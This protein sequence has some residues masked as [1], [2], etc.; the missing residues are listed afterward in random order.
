MIKL[1]RFAPF[2]LLFI[3]A[4][5]EG[6]KETLPAYITID[7]INF[8]YQNV[9]IVGNGGTA[10]TDA[11]IYDNDNLLGIFEL[12]ATVAVATQGTHELTVGA[13]I[14]LNGIS[15][16][17]ENYPF[18]KRWKADINLSPLDTVKVQPTVSYY[19]ETGISFKEE[20]QDVVLGI[21]TTT[22]SDVDLER[23]LVQGEPSYLDSY[24][25]RATLTIDNPGFKAVTTD[26]F[27]VPTTVTLP[28]Y[29]ELD[30]KCN[31]D[32][33]IGYIIRTPTSG[34]VENRL[35][36]LRSTVDIDGDLI[37]KH[38]YIDLTDQFAGRQDA[39]GFG[40]SF[41]AYYDGVHTESLIFMDNVKVV[42]QAP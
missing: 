9:S 3:L 12:P 13:G 33:V 20:F 14:K 31:Q 25:G 6:K 37:W 41:T 1:L 42:N 35:I 32:L 23:V 21:D 38:I 16:T 10:I 34:S 4:S 40:I 27:E 5:C 8:D 11:W 30:F 17:R 28:I 7:N 2:L 15:S 39:S 36:T 24:V 18:Y 19:L 26:L 29:L 22:V